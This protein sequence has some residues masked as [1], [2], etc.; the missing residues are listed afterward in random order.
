MGSKESKD[1]QDSFDDAD[2]SNHHPVELS[3]TINFITSIET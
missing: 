1:S 2:S 3:G